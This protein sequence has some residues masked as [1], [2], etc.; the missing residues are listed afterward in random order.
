MSKKTN[1]T[2]HVLNLISPMKSEDA[3]QTGT[4][5]SA[6]ATLPPQTEPQPMDVPMQEILSENNLMEKSGARLMPA[7]TSIFAQP[8][9][10]KQE[11][12]KDALHLS[13]NTE[14][15]SNLIKDNLEKAFALTETPKQETPVVAHK[16]HNAAQES[17][18]LQPKEQSVFTV[19]PEPITSEV[20]APDPEEEAP[21][22]LPLEDLLA[23][24]IAEYA[25]DIGA[26]EPEFAPRTIEPAPPI[27]PMQ[28]I[29][30]A[31]APQPVPAQEI[32]PA[33]APQSV[34]TQEIK[35]APAPQPVPAQEIHP[36]PAPQPVPTQEIKSA[37]EPTAVPE[38]KVAPVQK[39]QPEPE[40]SPYQCVNVCEQI[41]RALAPEY[42]ERF[43]VCSCDRCFIDVVAL[44]LTNLPPKYVVVEQAETTPLIDYYSRKFQTQV[45]AELVKACL[46]VQKNPRH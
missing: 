32:K 8:L 27:I 24:K 40:E 42:I 4:A 45:M 39:P 1:K 28:E 26:T 37:P 41:V 10:P 25:L 5:Q 33:P 2:A 23:D 44:T 38:Q 35:P 34:P 14:E 22:E 43:H 18:L 13:E 21:A 17:P 16:T 36:T 6:Q 15:L 9:A 46:T 11:G 19:R 20:F 30:P 31:P 3:A 12:I 29:K 7:G